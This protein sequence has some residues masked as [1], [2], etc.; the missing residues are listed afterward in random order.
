MEIDESRL[1]QEYVE[2]ACHQLGNI[3]RLKTPKGKLNLVLN[4]CKVI[5]SMLQESSRDGRPDGADLFF[6]CSVY[7]L[8]HLEQFE[9]AQ[10]SS[11]QLLKS[12]LNY[13]RH[14][15]QESFLHG[16]D[17]YYLQTLESVIEFVQNLSETYRTD[18]KLNAGEDLPPAAD[19][20][21]LPDEWSW[22][23][24]E[25]HNTALPQQQPQEEKK[26]DQEFGSLDDMLSTTP[27]G[28]A[29]PAGAQNNQAPVAT[30]RRS[31]GEDPSLLTDTDEVYQHQ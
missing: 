28:Q 26:R 8:L 18:L 17:D 16:Q 5:S 9:V 14:F 13:V 11:S 2:R 29:T 12:N 25:S 7:A 1:L 24:E 3:N 6:P 27:S 15:R 20:T 31:F 10:S 23:F 19:A 30:P 21:A 22:N 4:F